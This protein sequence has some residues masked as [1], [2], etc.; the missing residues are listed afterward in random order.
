MRLADVLAAHDAYRPFTAVPDN[1]GDGFL[2]C[3]N[4][5]FRA[6]R[7]RATAAGVRFTTEDFCGYGVASLA[8]LG[9]ILRARTI[10]YQDNVGVLR[11]AEAKRPGGTLRNVMPIKSNLI[12]HEAAHCVADQA[13]PATLTVR[14]TRLGAARTQALRSALGESFANACD[15]L[16]MVAADSSAHRYFY[17][18]NSFTRVEPRMQQALQETIDRVGWPATARAVYL[19]FLLANTLSKTI[20]DASCARLWALAEVAV[21]KRRADRRVL[22]V[23]TRVGLSLNLRFRIETAAFFLRYEHGLEQDVFRLNA[24]DVLAVL[25]RDPAL[26]T[27]ALGLCDLLTGAA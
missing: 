19:S 3:A 18:Q 8:A 22:E 1:V 20:D 25:E 6:V 15:L 11:R 10:P 16:G 23:V 21:P 24:Y 27:T 14:G 2:Y 9:A 13:L 26:R 5:V 17:D 12:M 4:P 7:D